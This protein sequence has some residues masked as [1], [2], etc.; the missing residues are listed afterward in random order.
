MEREVIY[1]RIKSIKELRQF[2]QECLIEH[3]EQRA[4]AFYAKHTE[5][6][7]YEQGWVDALK[8][9]RDVTGKEGLLLYRYIMEE[10]K[11]RKEDEDRDIL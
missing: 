5:M 10:R 7:Y 11:V 2:I 4:K 9:I 6:F 8:T 3:S 1:K